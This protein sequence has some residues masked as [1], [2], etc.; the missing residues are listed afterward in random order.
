MNTIG[1]K[2]LKTGGRL[3]HY[4]TDP[5]RMPLAQLGYQRKEPGSAHSACQCSVG[6]AASRDPIIDEL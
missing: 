6:G 5:V 1:C 3:P 2:V 4:G